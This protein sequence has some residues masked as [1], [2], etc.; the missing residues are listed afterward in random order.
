LRN[1]PGVKESRKMLVT[2]D[3]LESTKKIL[4]EIREKFKADLEKRP[5]LG[6]I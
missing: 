4:N 1:F 5:S 6:E 2:T 3:S